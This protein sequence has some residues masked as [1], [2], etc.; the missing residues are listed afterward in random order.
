[1]AQTHAYA[2]RFGHERANRARCEARAARLESELAEADRGGRQSAAEAVELRL[3][4]SRVAAEPARVRSALLLQKRNDRVDVSY[5]GVREL[6][7]GVRAP[8]LLQLLES[9]AAGAR[10]AAPVGP[11][12]KVQASNA[13]S[14]RARAACSVA[15]FV[16][17]GGQRNHDLSDAVTTTV[18]PGSDGSG[19][20]LRN[21]GA[22]RSRTGG[23][24]LRKRQIE[25][26][27]TENG[28]LIASMARAG[29]I[30]LWDDD[31]FRLFYKQ[32]HNGDGSLRKCHQWT[33]IAVKSFPDATQPGRVAGVCCNDNDAL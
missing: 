22:H 24:Q 26:Y 6:L 4:E 16:E 9:T 29:A 3:R 17:A 2:E 18:A 30:I 1:M 27:F 11:L 15:Q 14:R 23:W 19:A 21:I 28:K 7:R 5:D 8:S 32:S 25:T 13:E 31:F 33:V 20:I 12:S 10:R